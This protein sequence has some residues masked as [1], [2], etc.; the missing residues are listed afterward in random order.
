MPFSSSLRNLFSYSHPSPTEPPP[1]ITRVPIGEFFHQSRVDWSE[2][3]A[4]NFSL[5]LIPLVLKL[6]RYLHVFIQIVDLSHS[7]RLFNFNLFEVSYIESSV[8]VCVCFN[9]NVLCSHTLSF[10]GIK[11]VIFACNWFDIFSDLHPF[12]FWIVNFEVFLT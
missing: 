8:C 6:I 10:R 12:Y 11:L 3:R 2:V 7:S 4:G 1:F 5:H 9:V